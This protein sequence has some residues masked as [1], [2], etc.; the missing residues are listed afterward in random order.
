MMHRV[1][2]RAWLFGLLLLPA[3]AGCGG[4]SHVSGQVVVDGKPYTPTDEMIALVF[5]RED[6]T[7]SV[8]VSIQKDGSFVVY[9]PNNEGLPPGKYKVGY[10]SDTDG[11]KKK[12]IKAVTPDKSSMELDLAGGAKVNITIDLIKGTMTR[13]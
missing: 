12:R 8:S 10:Y 1:C 7:M 6:S 3:L 13:S 9:G 5:A 11:G 4:V 2:R